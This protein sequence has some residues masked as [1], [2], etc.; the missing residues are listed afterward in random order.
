MSNKKPT[1]EE[2]ERRL[3][4]TEAIVTTLRRGEVD[5]IISERKVALLRVAELEKAL[6]SSEENFRNSLEKSPLGTCIISAEG[7]ILYANQAMLDICGYSSVEE[8]KAMP[9]K[10]RYIPQSYAEHQERKEKR[11][12]GEFVPSNYEIS[13][14]RKDGEVRHLAVSRAEVT[15][16]NERQFE[17]LY[18]DIT[19]RKRLEKRLLKARNE[20]EMRVAERTAELEWVARELRTEI[21]E[22]E[23]AEEALRQSEK[24]YKA[25][26]EAR[27]MVWSLLMK[28]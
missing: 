13:I 8:L 9:T 24:K 26:F 18:H 28:Q 11:K 6:R 2:L 15:W 23:Q 4:D 27:S 14:V 22:R 20:L 10:D 21:A 17:A 1:Y 3:I 25:L 12:R 19:K 5:A 7:E 16:N